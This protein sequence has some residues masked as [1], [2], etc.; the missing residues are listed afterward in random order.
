M[1]YPFLVS[2]FIYC[3][4]REKGERVRVLSEERGREGSDPNGIGL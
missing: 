4:M 3:V 1:T 2:H